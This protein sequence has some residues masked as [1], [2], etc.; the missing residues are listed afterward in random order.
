MQEKGGRERLEGVPFKG[1]ASGEG[2]MNRNRL[3]RMRE[4]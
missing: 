2:S 1:K 4:T 3:K